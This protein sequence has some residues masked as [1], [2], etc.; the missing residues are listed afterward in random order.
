MVSTN[1]ILFDHRNEKAILKS[2]CPAWNLTNHV[3]QKMNH[4]IITSQTMYLPGLLLIIFLKTSPALSNWKKNKPHL[5]CLCIAFDLLNIWLQNV[6][7]NIGVMLRMRRTERSSHCSWIKIITLYMWHSLAVLFASPSV[8]VN[9]MDHVKSK[10]MFLFL[11]WVLQHQ[12]L[13]WRENPSCVLFGFVQVLYCISRPILW[14]VKP[15][16][17]W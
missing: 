16:S 9:V 17:L 5:P 13:W 14:L 11:P 12:D 3:E 10:L 6:S 8:V 7:H 1:I 4:I 15:R 2:F